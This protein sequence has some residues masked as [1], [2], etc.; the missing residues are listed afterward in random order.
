MVGELVRREADIAIAPLTINSQREQVDVIVIV[1]IA[2][3]IVMIAII[4]IAIII[5]AIIISSSNRKIMMIT[6]I[7]VIRW[8]TSQN[9]SCPSASPS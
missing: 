7:L 1:I 2:I 4:L 9:P 3:V 6:N 8:L 5:I